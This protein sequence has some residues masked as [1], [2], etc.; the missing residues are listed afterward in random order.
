MR[1]DRLALGR[2]ARGGGRRRQLC[3]VVGAGAL[4]VWG[5]ALRL[6]GVGNGGVI[7]RVPPSAAFAPFH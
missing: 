2:R 1:S 4:L 7:A 3:V 5:L 6:L